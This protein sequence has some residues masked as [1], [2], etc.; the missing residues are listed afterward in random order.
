MLRGAARQHLRHA[1]QHKMH[2]LRYQP[3]VPGRGL[4]C[5]ERVIAS[6]QFVAAIA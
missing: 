1:A 5:G 2:G 3:I 4:Q 6:E